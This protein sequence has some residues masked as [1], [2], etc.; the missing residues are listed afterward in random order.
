MRSEPDLDEEIRAAVEAFWWTRDAQQ[1]KQAR[2]GTADAGTRGAVTG[3]AHMTAIEQLVVK[4]LCETGLQ[5]DEILTR[6][7]LELP[8]F[9]RSQ[10]RWDLLVIADKKLIAAIE[11]KSQVGSFGNNF[12]NRSEEALGDAEDLWTAFREGRFGHALAPFVGYFFLLEH[13]PKVTR[14]VKNAEPH[15]K[16]DP[17]FVE[18]G[19]GVSYAMRYEI[20][21]R[22]LVLE[23]KYTA[24]CLTLSPKV[25]A[26]TKAAVSFPAEDLAFK[27]FAAVLQGHAVAFLKSR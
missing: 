2:E 23:R 26:D 15:F 13:A 1:K 16:V 19:K 5:P 17:I 11:F 14:L 21:L 10:K 4:L 12:N 18:G 7:A 9:Y 25:S 8:G 27:R 6:T 22:R 3:G 20:F 24:T